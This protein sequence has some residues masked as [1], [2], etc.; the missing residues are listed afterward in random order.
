[1]TRP[2]NGRDNDSIRSSKFVDFCLDGKCQ[3]PKESLLLLLSLCVTF[4][5]G[6]HARF[7]LF[8]QFFFFLRSLFLLNLHL[9]KHFS[10]C[11]GDANVENVADDALSSWDGKG[12]GVRN[13]SR[14][15]RDSVTCFC[16]AYCIYI[17]TGSANALGYYTAYA[18]LFM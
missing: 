4:L 9:D 12:R 14:A 18:T 1:M 2:S 5:K 13:R 8:F 7:F 6:P 17:L 10:S 16:S 15:K 11:P 3:K